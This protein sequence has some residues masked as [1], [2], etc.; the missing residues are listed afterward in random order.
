MGRP[1][2]YQMELGSP[3]TENYLGETGSDGGRREE[4]VQ[5]HQRAT[6]AQNGDAAA[7]RSSGM[8]SAF[9]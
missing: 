8:F 4:G 7:R 5:S 2:K 6:T 3:C 9:C 1:M